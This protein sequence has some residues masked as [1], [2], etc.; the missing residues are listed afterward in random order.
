MDKKTQAVTEI[1]AKS[2]VEVALERDSVPIIYDEVRA[3]LSVLDDQQV[4]DFLASKAIDLSAKSE[5]VRL[6]QESCSNYMK[7]FLEIILQNERQQFLYLIMKEV[8]KEL[9]LK[10][11]IFDIEVTT[12]VALSD[13]QKERLTALVE[14]K[15]ALTKR[16]LIEKIDDEIIGGFIIKANNK[17]IDTS[18]RSQLQELKMNLK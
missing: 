1:Y 7:Q 17:V 11:H 10:T 9:S 18:I 15:F 12:V 6:F 3:I 2:L 5:V 16:N 8:L 4:Q 13:D 14:K